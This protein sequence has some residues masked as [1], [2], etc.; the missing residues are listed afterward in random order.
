MDLLTWEYEGIVVINLDQL[1]AAG[2]IILPVEAEF[3]GERFDAFKDLAEQ[4]KKHGS[5]ILGQLSHPS[6]Q[7]ESRLGKDPVS[8]SDV[9]LGENQ[10]GKTF[11][12]LH[13]ASIEEVEHLKQCFLHRAEFLYKAGYCGVELHGAQPVL[14]RL[15]WHI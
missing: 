14:L 8:A 5:L 15:P 10:M 1:E 6:R 12:K 13:A 11:E 7:V 9:Q 4:S 3:S 2:T